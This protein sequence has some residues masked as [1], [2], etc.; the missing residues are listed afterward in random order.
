MIPT[1][2]PISAGAATLVAFSVALLLVMTQKWHGALS[3]DTDDGVQKF[4]DTPTPRV[5]GLALLAGLLTGLILLQGEARSI[6]AMIL[7]CGLPA[8]F[9]GLVEDT[10][11]SVSPRLRLLSA[12]LS[13]AAFLVFSGALAPLAAPLV[14]ENAGPI[15]S[16]CIFLL[17]GLGII[18]GLAGTTNAINIIDGFHGLAAGSLLI[19][20]AT[21]AGLAVFEGDWNLAIAIGVFAGAILGFMMLNFP[22][23]FLFL[24][25]AG[26]YL[27]G[28]V[29]GA[30]AVLL[31]S[32]T[33]VSAFVAILVMAYPV[34]ETLFSMFRKSRRAG[35]SPTQPDRVH[36][37]MLVSRRFGRFIAFG[38]ERPDWK[39]PLTGALMW[40]FSLVAACLAILA[41]GT[42]AGGIL[43]LVIFALFYARVYQLVSL[44]RPS[45]LQHQAERWGWD[46]GARYGIKK[47]EG[48]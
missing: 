11:K 40:P 24:G 15:F 3:L 25:D 32:R 20:S 36:L 17:G 44:Q 26:A 37:H 33:D 19:M 5:G 47:K 29:L 42:N 8:F 13:G 4:H 12:L 10:T 39:N 45:L 7:I 28:F 46:E 27:S 1:Y 14:P 35:S 23:G 21:L 43:G 18:V 31:S 22:G 34:Y 30:F 16:G 2:F 6:L 41:Q 9:A 48:K 38:L